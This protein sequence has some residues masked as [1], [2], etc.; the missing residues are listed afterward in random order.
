MSTIPEKTFIQE[1]SDHLVDN[2]ISNEALLSP[3]ICRASDTISSQRST[4]VYEY[5]QNL[6]I[7]F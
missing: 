3:D 2:Y 7:H 1:F 6:T 5:T 4:N